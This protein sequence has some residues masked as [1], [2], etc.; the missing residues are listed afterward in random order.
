MSE[1]NM[2]EPTP[3]NSSSYDQGAEAHPYAPPPGPPLSGSAIASLIFSLLGLIGVL[4]LVGSVIG[5]LLG[6]SARKE[7]DRS[8]GDVGGQGMAQA[9]IVL[10]WLGGALS[11]M[12]LCLIITGLVAVPGIAICAGLWGYAGCPF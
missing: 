11:V 6:H 4:P 2:S 8:A 3:E 7:I 1:Q 9:G 10:G 5:L 12:L